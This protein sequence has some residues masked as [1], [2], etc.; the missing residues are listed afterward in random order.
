MA[1]EI[2]NRVAAS[3]LEELNLENYFPKEQVV[4]FDLKPFLFMELILKEKE[5]REKL[6]QTDWSIYEGKIVA[7]TCTADAIIP[8]WAYMLVASNLQPYAREVIFGDEETALKE[9]FLKNISKIDFGEYAD[10][11]VVVKGCGNL[12]VGEYAYLEITNRLRPVAKSIMYGEACSTVP[13][14]KKK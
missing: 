14:F 12:P 1:E 3:A 7:V 10:K 8:V 6:Q 13:I 9:S 11:R 4:V 2:I 5:F